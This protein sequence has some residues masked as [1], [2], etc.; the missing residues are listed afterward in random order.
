MFTLSYKML[1]LEEFI[2]FLIIVINL[3]PTCSVMGMTTP[4]LASSSRNKFLHILCPLLVIDPLVVHFFQ[5]CKN[6]KDVVLQ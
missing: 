4:L 3:K 2:H 5:C 6:K 1:E